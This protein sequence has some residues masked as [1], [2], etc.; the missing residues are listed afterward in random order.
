MQQPAEHG[1]STT[2]GVEPPTGSHQSAAG[3]HAA[4]TAGTV[5]TCITTAPG[6]ARSWQ[7]PP[8]SGRA[9]ALTSMTCTAAL[10]PAGHPGGELCTATARHLCAPMQTRSNGRA[11]GTLTVLLGVPCS[12]HMPPVMYHPRAQDACFGLAQAVCRLPSYWTSCAPWATSSRT[13]STAFAVPPRTHARQLARFQRGADGRERAVQVL[14]R[15]HATVA[16]EA[17]TLL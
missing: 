10:Q 16:A 4:P 13:A 6:A 11:L 2:A 15:V 8:P 5:T 17:R 14:R 9:V 12:V 3:Q 1:G 7:T